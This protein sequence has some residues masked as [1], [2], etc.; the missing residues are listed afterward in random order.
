MIINN[1]EIPKRPTRKHFRYLVKLLA[2]NGGK[3]KEINKVMDYCKSHNPRF[4]SETFWSAIDHELY[5]R[6]LIELGEI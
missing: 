2:D 5:K 3:I 6:E 1:Y 4:C